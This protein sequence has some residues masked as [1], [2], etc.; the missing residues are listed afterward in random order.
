MLAVSG[1]LITGSMVSRN[2][3]CYVLHKKM[4]LDNK[5][6][7]RKQYLHAQEKSETFCRALVCISIFSFL[8]EPSLKHMGLHLRFIPNLSQSCLNKPW[9]T[10]LPGQVQDS[11]LLNLALQASVLF[12][13]CEIDGNR[14]RNSFGK[15]FWEYSKWTRILFLLDKWSTV[16]K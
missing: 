4:S 11:S 6:Q 14:N 12:F 7:T 1:L 16:L 15:R 10:C 5:N 3:S 8:S 9:G 2:I 13:E